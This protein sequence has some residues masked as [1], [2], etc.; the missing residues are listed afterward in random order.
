MPTPS[1]NDIATYTTQFVA[2]LDDAFRRYGAAEGLPP[3]LREA[4]KT[5][6]RHRFVHRFRLGDGPVQDLDAEQDQTLPVV[7]SDQVMCHIDAAGE[8]LASSNSQ[9]ASRRSGL[10]RRDQDRVVRLVA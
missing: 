2:M 6:P 5:T 9:P 4:V 3:R 8:L 10:Q 7:Y 1:E